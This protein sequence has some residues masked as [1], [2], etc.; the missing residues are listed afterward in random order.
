VFLFVI[1]LLFSYLIQF[2]L[3]YRLGC[4]AELCNNVFLCL[5]IA[6]VGIV[7]GGDIKAIVWIYVAII[8][9][10]VQ[11]VCLKRSTADAEVLASVMT[12]KHKALFGIVANSRLADVGKSPASW[13]MP[14]CTLPRRPRWRRCAADRGFQGTDCSIRSRE[15]PAANAP[16]IP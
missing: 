8:V 6:I 4:K 10:D 16:C 15:A 1:F 7:L 11:T 9:L 12:F 5:R 2:H 13:Q 14:L 3:V